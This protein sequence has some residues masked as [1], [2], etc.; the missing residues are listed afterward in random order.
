[1]CMP[2]RPNKADGNSCR[3]LPQP[4]SGAH[5]APAWVIWLCVCQTVGWCLSVSLAFIV[6]KE[7][8]L[9]GI[10]NKQ[11]LQALSIDNAW[12]IKNFLYYL[13]FRMLQ[14]LQN[15]CR[16]CQMCVNSNNKNRMTHPLRVAKNCTTHPYQ[17]FNL[18]PTP[19]LLRPTPPP[20]YFLTSPLRIPS[21]VFF[22]PFLVSFPL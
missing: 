18:W 16:L 7:L 12:S 5:W 21:W 10:E 15:S 3:W 22:F 11:R 2:M 9:E 20:P 1:M 17:G 8:P 4:G 13:T 19:S 14:H 6:R